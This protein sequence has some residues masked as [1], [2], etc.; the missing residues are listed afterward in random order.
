MYFCHSLHVATLSI[1]SFSVSGSYLHHC[2]ICNGLQFLSS[3]SCPVPHEWTGVSST[4]GN[5]LF[6][7]WG[8]FC[9]L[10]LYPV[11]LCNTLWTLPVCPFCDGHTNT[12]FDVCILGLPDFFVFPLKGKKIEVLSL[13]TVEYMTKQHGVCLE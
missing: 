10:Y 3:K 13:T 1:E 6:V 11:F 7:L 9:S 8:V 5:L 2:F 4:A 12:L